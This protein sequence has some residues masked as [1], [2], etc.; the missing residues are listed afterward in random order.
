M[1]ATP[2]EIQI[3]V[4]KLDFLRR[5]STLIDSLA[6]ITP[7]QDLLLKRE[8]FPVLTDDQWRIFSHLVQSFTL[9]N[10][11]SQESLAQQLNSI[12]IVSEYAERHNLS[13][14]AIYEICRAMYEF[15]GDENGEVNQ[16][17]E[18]YNLGPHI[19]NLGLLSHRLGMVS[20]DNFKEMGDYLGLHGG[21]RKRKIRKTRKQHKR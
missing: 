18:I 9:E 13:V 4:E 1:N 16:L 21:A 2:S 5:H 10:G 11:E 3:P 12:F 7:N 6:D 14:S 8:D 19:H 15:I 17:E 20:G